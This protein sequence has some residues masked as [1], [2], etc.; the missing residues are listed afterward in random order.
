MA[1]HGWQAA[2]VT[3]LTLAVLAWTAVP[4]SDHPDTLRDWYAA[5]DCAERGAC[6]LAGSATS[7]GGLH[8]GTVFPSVLAAVAGMGLDLPVAWWAA[9]GCA[10]LATGAVWLAASALSW[11][12]ATVGAAVALA[13]WAACMSAQ[14]VWAP[15]FA[16]ALGCVAGLWV[17]AGPPQQGSGLA[18]S[19]ALGAA[20]GALADCH[21]MAAAA[22]VGWWLAA[23]VPGAV[24]RAALRLGVSAAVALAVAWALAPVAFD[25]NLALARA[26]A[27]HRPL[28]AVGA[29][30]ACAA[31]AV[32]ARRAPCRPTT[33]LGVAALI[34]LG[35]AGAGHLGT[36]HEVHPRYLAAAAPAVAWWLAA[37]WPWSARSSAVAGLAVCAAAMGLLGGGRVSNGH[38]W[39]QVQ[40]LRPIARA[41]ALTWPD[42]IGLVQGHACR[43][44]AA[45]LG[46]ALPWRDAGPAAGNGPVLQVLDL[47]ATVAPGGR[48]IALPP[49]PHTGLRSWARAIDGWVDGGRGQVCVRELGLPARCE[50]LRPGVT[51]GPLGTPAVW[52]QAPGHVRAYPWMTTLR[53]P[54]G[55]ASETTV[56]L[57]FRGPGGERVVRI[58]D[59][60]NRRCPW[61]WTGADG[62]TA[63]VRGSEWVHLRCPSAGQGGLRLTRSWGPDCDDISQWTDGPP[64]LVEGHIDESDL[65]Q[66]VRMP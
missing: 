25:N 53:P 10:A 30:V 12:G 6:L 1:R 18:W 60:P 56:D 65:L 28:A 47:P 3:G 35:A 55:R 5:R 40:A 61:R 20:G 17:L 32:L 64:C 31:L 23:A 11:R 62:C 50:P 66:A 42:A 48:W 27:A 26:A 7:F 37:A 2:L 39:D 19:A 49:A 59:L 52:P 8:N 38:S 36:G 33:V 58:L 14:V 9:L 44:L 54:S 29:V 22:W 41:A 4:L 21:P 63:V 57:A 43:K 46:A 34:P 15:A 13:V 45:G 16:P 24:G 51:W